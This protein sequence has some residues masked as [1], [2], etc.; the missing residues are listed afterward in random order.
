MSFLSLIVQTVTTNFTSFTTQRLRKKKHRIYGNN[1]FEIQSLTSLIKLA[2]QKTFENINTEDSDAKSI[3]LPLHDLMERLTD[4][5]KHAHHKIQ[6]LLIQKLGPDARHV[7]TA[8]RAR[9]RQDEVENHPKVALVLKEEPII[10]P[11]IARSLDEVGETWGD[12]LQLL[13][14]YRKLYA[15]M[16]A[17]LLVAKER[18][19]SLQKS[20]ND[21]E[22]RE[23]TD[24]EIC[25][26]S[27]ENFGS[28]NASS[29]RHEPG[30][31]SSRRNSIFADTDGDR[32]D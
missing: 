20:M 30:F 29:S 18:I 25:E 8:E 3:H 6:N 24:D 19:L 5:L 17:E 9:I 28:V 26:M 16:V 1:D 4:R 21:R 10:E 13:N 27:D 11:K 7:I 31:A 14:E 22:G 2:K 15:S 23:K 12:E 32:S